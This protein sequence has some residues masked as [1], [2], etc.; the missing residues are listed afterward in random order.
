MKTDLVVVDTNVWLDY[1]LEDRPLHG[2]SRE[3][4]V[5]AV[6]DEVSLVIPSHCLKDIFVL[7]QSIMK[8]ANRE[9]GAQ[10]AEVAADVARTYAWACIDLIMELAAVCGSDE[11]DAWLAARH[12]SIH[13]D[14]EDNLVLSAALRINARLLVTN[15]K[16][17]IAHSPVAAMDA[18]TARLYLNAG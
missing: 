4:I 13:N 7:L 17:L 18:R 10:S 2:E 11:S 8:K 15:D 6:Q 1:L 3:F 16:A 5:Q 9:A 12:R 14:Y